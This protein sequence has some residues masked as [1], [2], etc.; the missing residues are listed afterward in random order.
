MFHDKTTHF[1]VDLHFTYE[2]IEDNTIKVQF[3][4]FADQL[5]DF[6]IKALG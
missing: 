3:K 1:E 6:L 4:G 2:K 5:A